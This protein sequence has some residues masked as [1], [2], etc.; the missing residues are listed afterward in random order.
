[1]ENIRPS[2][3]SNLF[4]WLSPVVIK[5]AVV[6]G[7]IEV[8]FYRGNRLLQDWHSPSLRYAL[9]ELLNRWIDDHHISMGPQPYP[10]VKQLWQ[11]LMPLVSENFI[12]D[13]S[14]LTGLEEVN[15]PQD[16]T[17]VWTLNSSLVCIEG[18]FEGADH[19]LGMGWFQKGE[20]IWSLSTHPSSAVD[21]QL[22]NLIV[23][24]QQTNFLLNMINPSLQPYLPIRVDFQYI[25]D[26]VLQVT[27]TDARNGKFAL[28]LQCNYP[29]LLPISQIPLQPMNVL[30]ANRAVIQFP[31]Q[32]LTP[33][34]YGLLLQ[35][36]LAV[37]Y[38][39]NVPV[40]IN[41]Q[42]PILRLY[43]LISDDMAEK[44]IQAN[45]IVSIAT[46]RAI[47][48][49][50]RTYENGV[51]K[52]IIT[53]TYQYQQ[54]ILDM[55]A[56]LA[57]Y[58]R[59]QRFIQ[60]YGIWFEWPHNSYNIFNTIQQQRAT[61]VLYPEEVMG[62]DTQRIALLNKKPIAHT[63]QLNGMTPVERGQDV[64]GQ[65]QYHGIPGGIVDESL[66]SVTMFINSCE[67]LLRENQRA[68]ILWLV[69]S[70]KKGSVTRAIND[71]TVRSYI[72]VASLVTL[73]DEPVLM[74]HSWTLV[75]FQALD[76]LLD[77]RFLSRPLSLLKWDW[78]LTS[79]TSKSALSPLIMHTLH[80]PEKYYEQF[81]AR[82]LF[83]LSGNYN[84]AAMGESVSI[85]NTAQRVSPTMPKSA[86]PSAHKKNEKLY[87]ATSLPPVSDQPEVKGTDMPS[88]G[89]PKSDALM[90][91]V[92]SRLISFWEQARKWKD[93]SYSRVSLVPHQSSYPIYTDMDEKELQW[94]FYWRNEVRNDRYPPTD[95]GYIL[96]H[97]Y[98]TLACI[99]FTTPA[100]ACTRLRALWTHYRDK[101]PQLDNYLIPWIADFCVVY[102]LSFTAMH[103][104]A[105]L[106]TV[107]Q[108]AVDEQL[109][110]EAWLR[111][112][113][114]WAQMPL[115]VLYKLAG[116]DRQSLFYRR[117]KSNHIL[118]DIH[119]TSIVG[120]DDYLRRQKN[121][122]GIIS[123]YDR[124]STHAVKREPFK[125]ALTEHTY[126][127][128]TVLEINAAFNNIEFH[129]ALSGIL[130]YADYL[131]QKLY[132][133]ITEPFTPTIAVIWQAA[134][135]S[136]LISKSLARLRS[137]MGL[138]E[139]QSSTSMLQESRSLLLYLL[140]K[141]TSRELKQLHIM[142]S[143]DAQS[144]IEQI[145]VKPAS[146][147]L[148]LPDIVP[149]NVRVQRKE[150]EEKVPEST[151]RN[152]KLPS[153][154][155]IIELNQKFIVQLHQEAEKLQERLFIVDE[156]QLQGI[157]TPAS[158]GSQPEMEAKQEVEN[159][160]IQPDINIQISI[161]P[162]Q[163]E[164]EIVREP[165][166]TV[167]DSTRSAPQMI[168]S[169]VQLNSEAISKL[170][171]ESEQL[172]GRLVI[173]GE[174]KQEQSYIT[175]MPDLV[176]ITP[177]TSN[178]I[179]T[180]ADVDEDWRAIL[181][182]WQPV[183]WEIITLLYQGQQVQL[184]TVEHK[185]RRP[186]SKL[187]DEVNSPVDEQL[188]DLLIDPDTR[189]IFDHLYTTAG[190]LVNWYISSKGR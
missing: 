55:N 151:R 18:H 126:S 91:L 107:P 64:F 46:L 189:T 90:K 178:V 37:F 59:N 188:G 157:S 39:T 61:K 185:A 127:S 125:G 133:S 184:P 161:E 76:Q 170:R 163:P 15:Q 92:P 72:T 150:L 112:G 94:Y 142:H 88:K 1:M 56:L 164:S 129:R 43:H 149:G 171:E 186:I 110:A 14:A 11:N 7:G 131:Q 119:R 52:Y 10:L 135:E 27:V 60:Q 154:R 20:K 122:P 141:K 156:E 6:D 100:M 106:L 45:P 77:E 25:T 177:V 113:G 167:S 117:N 96:M 78:A 79:V 98:E 103:W 66:G 16:V 57:A 26:F 139:Q 187:I 69:P 5:F 80:L 42:L 179:D 41:E 51:G 147:L 38:G 102:K 137:S 146:S 108:C 82:Y 105:F 153:K 81:C 30:L 70:N 50:I 84:S 109:I 144:L 8:Q 75:I 176:V 130:K 63:I 160:S 136:M 29:Q 173:E 2:F 190:S 140:N 62:F 36:P 33:V 22:K 73:R 86:S 169:I 97:V 121:I 54:H 12:V 128:I 28:A 162:I 148:A 172:Q 175:S 166:Q 89:T 65:L 21:S 159:A 40:F 71:S 145:S 115:A 158:P 49:F 181:Q 101:F 152:P 132:Q 32:A 124:G 104:Y 183:H 93:M 114:D 23:P 99:G 35:E 165:A 95:I 180:V 123:L 116:L 47:L 24:V 120:V 48:S 19:Y 67:N 85:L 3:L 168:N 87:P 83:S 111:Q 155:P 13:A 68:R 138:I 4:P 44:I 58:Q 174:E 118:E 134:I 31:H 9:P 74:L 53:T 182:Q 143:T 17:L 34:M